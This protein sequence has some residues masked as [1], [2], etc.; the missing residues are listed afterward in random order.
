MQKIIIM[1][2]NVMLITDANNSFFYW[3]EQINIINF[4]NCLKLD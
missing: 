2:I 3:A 1:N 4:K